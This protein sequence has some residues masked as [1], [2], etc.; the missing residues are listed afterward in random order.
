MKNGGNAVGAVV[1]RPVR[2]SIYRRRGDKYLSAGG[3]DVDAPLW[4]EFKLPGE[5]GAPVRIS[6]RTSNLAEGVV[7]ANSLVWKAAAFA[8]EQYLRMRFATRP[9][10]AIGAPVPVSSPCVPLSALWEVVRD[11]YEARAKS[12]EAYRQQCAKF[13]KYAARHGVEFAEQVSRDFAEEYAKWLFERVTTAQK[14]IGCLRRIWQLLFPDA[15][16]NPW[17][18]SIRLQPKERDHAMNYRVLSLNEVRR[19][20]QAAARF[21]D[22]PSPLGGCVR[23]LTR[24]VLRDI[25]DAIVF[26]FRYGLRI[27]SFEAVRWADFDETKGTWVHRPPKTS[28]ATLGTD[29][30]L[31]PEAAAILARRKAS[32]DFKSGGLV[33]GAFACAH[34]KN[35][36]MLNL[37]IKRIFKLAGVADSK[38]KGRASWHSLRATFITRLTECG[39]PSAIVKELAQHT[40]ADVTQRYVHVSLGEKLKWLSQLPELGEVDLGA[41]YPTDPDVPG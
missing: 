40:K 4:F 10:A 36:S 23:I 22:D 38:L 9:S 20:R 14:H 6:L 41:E 32:P 3:D 33:F 1:L 29:Y 17:V 21:A 24:E 37:G 26:S 30:P 28:R 25:A 12:K 27:G 34:A 15:P 19:I 16:S 7:R 2:G 18:L 11:R 39:C 35:E 8:E 31:L 5:R 13:A